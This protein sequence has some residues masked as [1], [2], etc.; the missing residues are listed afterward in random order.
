MNA[1]PGLVSFVQSGQYKL[2]VTVEVLGK[3]FKTIDQGLDKLMRGVSGTK[4]AVTL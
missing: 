1:L 3:G 2:P 4:Y